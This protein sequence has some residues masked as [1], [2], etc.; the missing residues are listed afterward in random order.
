MRAEIV[1]ALAEHIPVIAAKARQADIE[2]LWSQCRQ[3]PAQCMALGMR[4]SVTA[5]TGLVDGEPV[6]MFGATPYSILA[7]QGVAWMVGST[8]LDHLRVQK[9]LLKKSREGLAILQG[10]F[11]LLFNHVDDRNESAKRWLTW[12][13]FSFGDPQPLGPDLRSFRPFWRESHAANR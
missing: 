6:L 12:L 4:A 10:Q 2:E 1:P 8:A 11:P 3:T 7:G 9:A 13:G 5:F